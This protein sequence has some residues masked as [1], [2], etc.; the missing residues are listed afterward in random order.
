VASELMLDEDNRTRFQRKRPILQSLMLGVMAA[1]AL[2][3][4]ISTGLGQALPPGGGPLPELRR[5]TNGEIE[6]VRPKPASRPE[7][8][9]R[10]TTFAP[11]APPKSA[12]LYRAAPTA[13][14]RTS[15]GPAQPV[16]V[17]A[18]VTPHIPDTSPRGA[19]VATYSVRT[20]DG[21]PFTGTVRFGAPY[22]D[23]GG[24]FALSDN[25]IIVNPDGPGVGPNG[26]TVT[27]HLTLEAFP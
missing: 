19:V 2:C 27:K 10:G 11:N 14:V 18:P 26:T 17:V 24:A 7:V 20:S 4:D 3:A 15:P 8:G 13:R 25:K 9:Q 16:I 23:G 12:P 6:A 22:Y 1:L 21:S 5:G